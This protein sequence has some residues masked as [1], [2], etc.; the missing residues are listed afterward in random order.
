MCPRVHMPSHNQPAHLYTFSPHLRGDPHSYRTSQ[1]HTALPKSDRA[2]RESPPSGKSYQYAIEPL[3]E[4]C[5]LCA[6]LI[7]SNFASAI[8]RVQENMNAIF[9]RDACE[10]IR[11]PLDEAIRQS[12]LDRGMKIE[13]VTAPA[14]ARRRF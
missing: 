8:E 12:H 14:F 1:S 7:S 10:A 3:A 13:V 4:L 2:L 11:K 5:G 6:P 9:R